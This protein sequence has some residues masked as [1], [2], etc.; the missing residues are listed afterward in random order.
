MKFITN[1]LAILV[2]A[3]LFCIWWFIKKQPN[4][5]N[6]NF[7]I[8]FT[9]VCF[10]LFGILNPNKESEETQNNTDTIINTTTVKE[11]TTA[12]TESKT[13]EATTEDET[14][15]EVKNDGPEYNKESNAVFAQAFMDRLN[16]LLAEAGTDERVSVQYYDNSL[17]YVFVSQSYKYASNASIQEMADVIYSHKKSFFTEWAI[18]NGYDLSFT[19]SPTLIIKSEDDT[20][21]AEESVLFGEMKRKIDN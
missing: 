20:V 8:V 15:I 7:S 6:R 11:T 14:T 1:V 16:G 13:T 18:E 5:K 2:I 9:I 12:T 10:V 17:I 21:L 19:N 3:G 4:S